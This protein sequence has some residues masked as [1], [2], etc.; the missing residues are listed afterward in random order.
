MGQ[1]SNAPDKTKRSCK[2]T[3]RVEG[4]HQYRF[5]VLEF[6]HTRV[7]HGSLLALAARW[8]GDAKRQIKSKAITDFGRV[9]NPEISSLESPF[10]YFSA[11]C[12]NTKSHEHG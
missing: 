8:L 9:H 10:A 4:V 2:S 11:H 6:L 7:V 1:I 5:G 3:S 12:V